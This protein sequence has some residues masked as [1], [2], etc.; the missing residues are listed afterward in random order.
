MRMGMVVTGFLAIGMSAAC[1]RDEAPGEGVAAG[2]AVAG[3]PEQEMRATLERMVEAQSAFFAQ[4]DRFTSE[5]AVLMEQH[6]FE[7]VGSAT[8]VISFAGT[9][10][11]WGYLATAL[12]P[13]SQRQCE[14]HHGRAG[15]DGPEFAGQ[16]VCEGG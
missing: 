10:P 8:T 11:E 4:N 9:Q 7:P 3:D 5:V 15:P 2:A 6:G 13:T 1:G 16:I 12:H 14:V